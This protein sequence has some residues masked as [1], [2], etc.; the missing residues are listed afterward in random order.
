LSSIGYKLCDGTG[1]TV[2]GTG[3]ASNIAA[4][5]ATP[6][7]ACLAGGAFGRY[8]LVTVTMDDSQYGVFLDSNGANNANIQDLTVNYSP[9]H[10]QP[11]IRLRHNQTLQAGSLSK[12]DTCGI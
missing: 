4:T 5:A 11:T 3:L 10:P 9:T 7:G 2:T 1:V 8:I 12:L 6:S